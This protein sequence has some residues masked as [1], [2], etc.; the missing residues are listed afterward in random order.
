MY[1]EPAVVCCSPVLYSKLG[2]AD[3][4]MPAEDSESVRGN[5]LPFGFELTVVV[6][7]VAAFAVSLCVRAE[8]VSEAS[9]YVRS[10]RVVCWKLTLVAQREVGRA[11]LASTQLLRS[12]GTASIC[13]DVNLVSCDCQMLRL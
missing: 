9:L 11:L 8:V 2:A 4:P 13:L 3:G 6:S 5:S 1:K 10:W 12:D 7:C